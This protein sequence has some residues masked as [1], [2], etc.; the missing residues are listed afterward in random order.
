MARP[1]PEEDP[2]TSATFAPSGLDDI[3]SNESVAVGGNWIL[4]L[5]L[6]GQL[7][8][9]QAQEQR[10]MVTVIEAVVIEEAVIEAAVIEATNKS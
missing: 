9:I 8:Q 3:A 1:M 5:D 10:K 2:V 4:L 6:G 7:S